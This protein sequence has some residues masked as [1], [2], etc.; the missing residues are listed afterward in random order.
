MATFY[1]IERSVQQATPLTLVKI[2]TAGQNWYLTSSDIEVMHDSNTYVPSA[3]K[4]STIEEVT[5]VEKANMTIT[6]PSDHPLR[7]ILNNNGYGRIFH[8]TVFAR[9]H[10]IDGFVIRWKGRIIN[11][12]ITTQELH[13]VTESVF[14]SLRR[15]G[16]RRRSSAACTHV[17]YSS[18]CGVDRQ[19]FAFS[20][21]VIAEDDAF[22]FLSND[23]FYF[24]GLP[25]NDFGTT[26]YIYQGY[27]EYTVD[28]ILQKVAMDSRKFA[29]FIASDYNIVPRSFGLSIGDVVK[30]YPSCDKTAGTCKIVFHNIDNYGGLLFVPRKNPFA[31]AALY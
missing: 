15:L 27:L 1:D 28:G 24:G 3:F 5:N 21:T 22:S 17:L 14:T 9:H 4:L 18:D 29:R 7:D 25:E 6:L 11:I 30:F 16:V 31:G 8:L 2:S 19:K 20:Y 13:L 23:G 10:L 26:N 12:E